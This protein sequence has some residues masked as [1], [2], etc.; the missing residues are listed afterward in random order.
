MSDDDES[1]GIKR[2]VAKDGTEFIDKGD[3]ER[4]IVKPDPDD[5]S[6]AKEVFETGLDK[7]DDE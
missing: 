2:W 4:F 6:I 5:P 7:D 1:E 3:G